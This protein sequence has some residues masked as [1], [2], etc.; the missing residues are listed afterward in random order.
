MNKSR[1]MLW[2]IPLLCSLAVVGRSMWSSSAPEK[3]MTHRLASEKT[4]KNLRHL[5]ESAADTMT[6]MELNIEI[7]QES[8]GYDMVMNVAKTSDGKPGKSGK[9]S[10]AQER[11]IKAMES[12]VKSTVPGKPV[13]LFPKNLD[14]AKFDP[15]YI[16]EVAVNVKSASEHL[17]FDLYDK[18]TMRLLLSRKATENKGATVYY[19]P[20]VKG[21]YI[22]RMTDKE[23]RILQHGDK[24]DLEVFVNQHKVADLD[25]LET[26]QAIDVTTDGSLTDAVVQQ[27]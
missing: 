16:L 24:G 3:Q 17:T 15:A 1:K 20:L 4:G 7:S 22:L 2:A 19:C 21:Q 27:V 6:G 8:T 13:Y 11:A 12:K 5:Q 9:P 14:M 10:P 23:G 25:A 18:S 26:A